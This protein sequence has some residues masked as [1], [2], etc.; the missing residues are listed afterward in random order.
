MHVWGYV[1]FVIFIST[2]LVSFI[3]IKVHHS[4]VPM[5]MNTNVCISIHC[6]KLFLSLSLSHVWYMHVHSGYVCM[7]NDYMGWKMYTECPVFLWNTSWDEAWAKMIFVVIRY[8]I[9]FESIQRIWVVWVWVW[10]Y[11]IA[12]LISC[13]MSPI[14][15]LEQWHLFE[16][17][18]Y[19]NTR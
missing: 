16:Y 12:V 7:H 14:R 1:S 6:Y 15:H 19:I 9:H 2:I 10:V 18:K 8:T 5:S 3:Q 13:K 4:Y 11:I 17:Q